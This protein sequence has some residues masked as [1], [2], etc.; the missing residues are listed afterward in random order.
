MNGDRDGDRNGGSGGAPDIWV[1]EFMILLH[2]TRNSSQN[3]RLLRW[4]PVC[5]IF[6]V[7]FTS[8]SVA[9]FGGGHLSGMSPNTPTVLNS[10]YMATWTP[11]CGSQIPN[12]NPPILTMAVS[13]S[14]PSST[15][16]APA[17]A[18]AGVAE[19]KASCSTLTPPTSLKARSEI[20]LLVG[21]PTRSSKSRWVIVFFGDIP[22]TLSSPV[23]IWLNAEE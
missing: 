15:R 6:C 22:R 2:R 18:A 23:E 17:T 14:L 11:I 9:I 3:G 16:K 4:M 1:S 5:F 20:S 19:F 7:G 13:R 10:P 8:F 21:D 12:E